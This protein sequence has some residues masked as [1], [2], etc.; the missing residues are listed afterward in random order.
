MKASLARRR[1]REI[2]AGSRCVLPGSAYDAISGRICESLGFE[3]G[4]LG[5][6][7]ASL[8]VLGAPDVMVLTLTELAEQMRR[9]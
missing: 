1:L 6:S 7:A 5:G 9:I 4:M 8:A 3:L 2:L